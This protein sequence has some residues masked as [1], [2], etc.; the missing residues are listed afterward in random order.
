M[1]RRYTKKKSSRPGYVFC[2]KMVY[3]DASKAL[4][5]AKYLKSVVNVEY[6]NFD[7]T[8]LSQVVGVTPIIVQLTNI[9]QGD[10]TNTRDGASV[11]IVSLRLAYTITTHASAPQTIARIMIV[12]DK[13]TNQA[14]Y[15]AADLFQDPDTGENIISPRN[16]D[17]SRRFRV[18]YDKLHSYSNVGRVGDYH[19]VNK[20]LQLKIRYDG[21]TPSIADLTQ[22]SLSLVM[23]C[24]QASN[25]CL[26]SHNTRLR[27]VD[28]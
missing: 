28:N 22:T 9:P 16:L 17:N 20:K 2:G 6:K 5:M 1:P 24:N 7:V 10:T 21:S 4:A 27:Y 23:I 8:T 26:V 15:T 19:Q 11:K 25:T 18:L 3:S 13:Q 14:I 12:C